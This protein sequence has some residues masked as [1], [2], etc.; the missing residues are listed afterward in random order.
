MT[1]AA[2]Q[3]APLRPSSI[4]A[5]GRIGAVLLAA[6]AALVLLGVFLRIMTFEMRNDEHLYAPPAVLLDEMRLYEDVFYNH[7]PASA[8]LFHAAAL[9]FGGERVLLPARLAVFCAWIVFAGL[10][11]WAGRRLGGSALLGATLVILVLTNDYLMGVSG[12]TATNNILP[13]PIAFAGL[14]LFLL[15]TGGRQGSAA[16]R[17]GL[18]FVAG[19]LLSVAILFKVN[20][21]AFAFATALGSLFLPAG[22][23][24]ADRLRRVI[25]P[26]ALGGLAGALPLLPLVLRGPATFWANVVAYHTGPHR[27]WWAGAAE[28]EPGLALSLSGKV[29]LAYDVYG[30]GANLLLFALCVIGLV[31]FAAQKGRFRFGQ[32]ERCVLF[33]LIALLIPLGMA[34]LPTPSF[35]QYFAPPLVVLPLLAAILW[36]SLGLA[37]KAVPAQVMTGVLLLG[38]ALG[39]PR[40]L[41]AAPAL[42]DPSGWT[43]N[44]VHA[45]GVALRRAIEAEGQ[46]GP[47][48]TLLPVY[49]LEA[50]LPVYPEFATGQ[51]A[52]RTGDLLGPELRA[53]YVTTAPSEVEAFLAA[54]PPAA[55][56]LGFV[57][58]IEA[59]MRRF[60]RENGYRQVPDFSVTDRYGSGE[61]WVRKDR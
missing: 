3:A 1:T 57:P 43:V 42:A 31:L 9:P 25:L 4:R 46:A 19:I 21:V 41:L 22:L 34:F 24:A 51:F 44:R 54:D 61:L 30:S 59:P 37:G 55:L 52:Y 11:F 15:G 23:R 35:P 18:V 8:W 48:A 17:S 7:T 58:E 6:A 50:G 36:R 27:D 5:G 60:A 33:L 29:F 28:T 56:L 32:E 45:E 40:L 47:V 12:V 49:P 38:L 26:L 10:V 13:L 53:R 16:P 2:A 20:A 39:L 14:S